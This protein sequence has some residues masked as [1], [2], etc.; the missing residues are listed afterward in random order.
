MFFFLGMCLAPTAEAVY[1][2]DDEKQ[3]EVTKKDIRKKEIR[4]DSK[5]REFVAGE[6]IV[7]FKKGVSKAKKS[8]KHAKRK[9]RRLKKYKNLD[10]EHVELAQDDNLEE[11]IAKYKDDPEVEYAEP[12]YIVYAQALPDDPQFSQT[13]GLLNTGQTGGTAGADI[14]APAAWDISTGDSGVV[15]G[16]IDTGV[17][18]TH[19]DLVDNIWINPGED[20]NYNGIIEPEE[21]NG[22]DDD[23]NG[24][25]DDF[26]G[27]NA[28][29]GSGD[30]M[31]DNGHGTHC[32]GT[33][34]ATGNNGVGVAGVN[35]NVKIIGCKFLGSSGYGSVSDA[36]TCMDYF[37][38][39]KDDGVDIMGTSNSYGRA[40]GY[41]QTMFD[42][43]QAHM[44][45]DM[46]FVV[47]AGN[48]TENNDL[49][50]YYPTNYEVPNVI[51]VAATDHN[52]AK[53]SFSQY[54]RRKVH[55]GAPGV[56]ITSTVPVA[57]TYGDPSGYNTLDGTSMAAPHVA[58]LAALLKADE[59]TRN[60]VDIK[61]LILAGGDSVP[62]MD[63]ITITGK[64]LNAYGSLSCTDSPVLS[65]LN[66]DFNYTEASTPITLSVLS[67]NCGSPV[68]PVTVS[69]S[70]GEN[71]NL[72]DDGI[73][74][75]QFAGDGI[76]SATW[77]PTTGL[78]TITASSLAGSEVYTPPLIIVDAELPIGV[79][80]IP[81]T[82]S[83][84]AVSGVEPY[85]WAFKNGVLPVGLGLDPATGIISG[86]PSENYA[87]TYVVTFEV[88]DA[89]GATAEKLH[90]IVIN[91]HLSIDN[92]SPLIATVNAFFSKRVLGSGGLGG[93]TY[94]FSIIAGTLPPGIGMSSDSYGVSFYGNPSLAGT[95]NVMLEVT[96]GQEVAT[97]QITFIVED[98]TITTI[99]LDNAKSGVAYSFQMAAVGGV[100]PYTW[101]DLNTLPSG[102]TLDPI[103]G[104]ISG[105]TLE[106]GTFVVDIE[107]VDAN[108][109]I[110]TRQY[111]LNILEELTEIWRIPYFPNEYQP[112]VSNPVVDSVGDVFVSGSWRSNSDGHSYTSTLKYDQLGNEIWRTDIVFSGRTG[113]SL[114][115]DFA[116]NGFLYHLASDL[117]TLKLYKYDPADGIEVSSASKPIPVGSAIYYFRRGGISFD[118]ES[119]V[120]A[121]SDAMG[122]MY[123]FKYDSDL[124]EI[125][126]VNIDF[127]TRLDLGMDITVDDTGN[128]YVVGGTVALEPIPN[129]EDI[130]LV[131]L[132]NDGNIIWERHYDMS[133]AADVASGVAINNAGN[134]LVSGNTNYNTFLIEYDPA[135]NIVDEYVYN[136]VSRDITSGIE[137]DSSGNVFLSGT[138][139][140]KF[141]SL[142]GGVLL[143]TFLENN[144]YSYDSYDYIS[145]VEIDGRGNIYVTD[146]IK[147]EIIKFEGVAPPNSAPIIGG[148]PPVTV[149]EDTLYTFTPTVSDIDG[150]T[151]IFSIV[152][153]PAWATIDTDTGTLSGTPTNDDVGTTVG[154]VISVSDNEYSSSLQP[155]DLTVANVNDAPT[156]ASAGI[157]TY[158]GQVGTTASG[159][160]TVYDVDVGD[161]HT[162]E[163]LTQPSTGFAE[164]IDNVITFTA[165]DVYAGHAI[166]T[167]LATDSGG[168]SVEGTCWVYIYG[169]NDA[170]VIGG[171][172]PISVDE[173]ALY[174]F[175]PTASDEEDD[176]LE[177]N[178]TNQPPW[179]TFDSVTGNLSGT[180]TGSD[181]GTYIDIV[182]SVNDGE[183]FTELPPFDIEVVSVDPD[184]DE[185][186]YTV[187]ADG[188]CDDGD[189]SIYPGA[190]EVKFDGIDQN[191]NGYDL[192]IEITRARYDEED[193]ELS[194]RATSDLGS[195]ANLIVEGFG[196]MSWRSSRSRWEL[197]ISH[198]ELNELPATISV[199]GVEGS[200]AISTTIR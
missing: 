120:Y 121:V 131:K 103:T 26:H 9:A 44:D 175:T 35:W 101:S 114:E 30:P 43:I 89:L 196:A 62:A 67:I 10:I 119:N 79:I 179:A 22:I 15:I 61:N 91:D 76:F 52:D 2:G 123:V 159:G 42:A 71:I 7:K 56:G 166:F 45:R 146:K 176:S 188:D 177:F 183:L 156:E 105:I 144:T 82:A 58:G 80:D 122:E 16:V 172:P 63:G 113:Q 60:W 167:F 194:I 78:E 25:I 8:S 138:H 199:T 150:D 49:Y 128:I 33:I 48:S 186:G 132:D 180:P 31:D 129:T 36:V 93:G 187:I 145:K 152:N 170:P 75:D 92:V 5:G 185:D 190:P 197:T 1:R 55:I 39:L 181:I 17:D 84:S 72:L 4:K 115:I 18:Y 198:M 134:I 6:L 173:N 133:G 34:G 106:T 168:L 90:L 11:A 96:D 189:L 66:K 118:S 111:S 147:D 110:S 155:F 40:G 163:I 19:P 140:R 142:D 27:I 13:W 165:P 47:A 24:Y 29:N 98:V 158:E 174:T 100:P 139:L 57:G 162:L 28:M 94:L 3:V 81:Y 38:S 14:N 151:L 200:E 107:L 104:A 191:C 161:T 23:G 148:E 192:T 143:D 97:S 136:T 154:I 135:G 137:L 21:Q 157:I 182:I 41:L 109:S 117:R 46:L 83:L 127:N 99:S 12:N 65:L 195:N 108:G 20:L 124:N 69:T 160:V 74:P 102:L 178:I 87:Y 116:P 164:V 88:T 68:G 64:R 125:W 37:A 54:G 59:P 50:P 153:Q 95:Y 126:T 73:A 70:N 86:T 184:S 112:E 141:S 193:E 77:T 51:S 53:A 130:I 149:D 85:S 169:V 171:T 32:S